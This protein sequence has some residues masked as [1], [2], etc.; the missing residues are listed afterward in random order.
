[1]IDAPWCSLTTS[2][3]SHRHLVNLPSDLA[4]LYGPPQVA[5][6]KFTDGK[7]VKGR[8]EPCGVGRVAWVVAQAKGISMEE[9][10]SFAYDNTIKLFGLEDDTER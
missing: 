6:E 1:M 4:A 10:C 5:P 9:V 3:A 8:M 7:G 2:H